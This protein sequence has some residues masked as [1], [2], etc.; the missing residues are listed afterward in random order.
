MVEIGV[1]VGA[2]DDTFPERSWHILGYL[3]LRSFV[4]GKIPIVI[5]GWQIR[6]IWLFCPE[7][8]SSVT[9]LHEIAVNTL[10]TFQMPLSWVGT[11][12]GHGHYSGSNIHPS[13]LDGPL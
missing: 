12:T 13:D 1:I 7:V 4:D 10:N 2:G 3:F 9:H 11:E 8:N 5:V 6:I